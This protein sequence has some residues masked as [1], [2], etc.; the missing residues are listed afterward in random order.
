[1]IGTLPSCQSFSKNVSVFDQAMAA[2]S[3]HSYPG[4]IVAAAGFLSPSPLLSAGTEID[5]A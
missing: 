3:N 2:S 4:P 1:M 5:N